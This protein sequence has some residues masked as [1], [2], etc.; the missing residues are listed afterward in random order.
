MGNFNSN[1]LNQ[2]L[3]HLPWNNGE[4]YMLRYAPSQEFKEG[5]IK[6]DITNQH[7][8][9]AAFKQAVILATSNGTQGHA[10][11]FKEIEI[12]QKPATWL[13][14]DSEK[15]SPISLTS[16]SDWTKLKGSIMTLECSSTWDHLGPTS[17]L[18]LADSNIPFDPNTYVDNSV[19]NMDDTPPPPAPTILTIPQTLPTPQSTDH[20]HQTE[21]IH[22][23]H[24]GSSPLSSILKNSSPK[25]YHNT[26]N[27]HHYTSPSTQTSNQ[28][29]TNTSPHWNS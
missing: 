19:I 29:E 14:L 13:L 23:Q 8:K 11:T 7:L 22:S 15:E 2:F 20:T 28:T 21:N 17:V 24:E 6:A 5:E 27:H 3:H 4:N 9:E 12:A 10:V 26:I 16:P 25:Q 1:I 18:H